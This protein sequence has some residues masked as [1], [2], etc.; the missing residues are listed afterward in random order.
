MNTCVKVL[1]SSTRKRELIHW[2]LAQCAHASSLALCLARCARVFARAE[3]TVILTSLFLP[4]TVTQR[5]CP[6]NTAE[7]DRKTHNWKRAR[8]K[9]VAKLEVMSPTKK[10]R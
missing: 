5:E 1:A 3:N 7:S 6:R 10:F 9:L 4:R 2:C 8:Q